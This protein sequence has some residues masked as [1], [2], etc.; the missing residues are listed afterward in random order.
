MVKDF[1]NKKRKEIEK[2]LD[3]IK[4]Q[5]GIT[6]NKIKNLE[7]LEAYQ[8]NMT[9]TSKKTWGGCAIILALLSFALG[10]NYNWLSAISI[11]ALMS[12]TVGAMLYVCK[13]ICVEKKRNDLNLNFEDDLDLEQDNLKKMLIEKRRL[14]REL[15]SLNQQKY[16]MQ[17]ENE[18][19]PFYREQKIRKRVLLRK[20]EE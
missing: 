5:V 19:F 1:L 14:G 11:F 8:K 3:Y 6:Q 9:I 18:F 16:N 2:D 15:Q 20:L 7:E 10:I 13:N 12:G 17:Q 4:E